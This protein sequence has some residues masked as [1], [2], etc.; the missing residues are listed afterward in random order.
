MINAQHACNH[1]NTYPTSAY[2]VFVWMFRMPSRPHLNVRNTRGLITTRGFARA[3]KTRSKKSMGGESR[4]RLRL[5]RVHFSRLNAS[6]D[7]PACGSE[8]ENL[9]ISRWTHKFPYDFDALL[10]GRSVLRAKAECGSGVQ[11]LKTNAPARGY[12]PSDLLVYVCGGIL[13]RTEDYTYKPKQRANVW[14]GIDVIIESRALFRLRCSMW[15]NIRFVIWRSSCT[16]LYSI[17][18]RSLWLTRHYACDKRRRA[19]MMCLCATTVE[20]SMHA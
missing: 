17:K 12:V 14:R 19:Q 4:M 2:C 8:I 10:A 18:D 1:T 16:F 7:Q 11:R 15:V 9:L 3:K 20:E 6:R 13:L 5:T